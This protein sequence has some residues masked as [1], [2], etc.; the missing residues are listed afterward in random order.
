MG[1]LGTTKKVKNP[2]LKIKKEKIEHFLMH[3]EPFHWSHE[4]F[5]KTLFV[6]ILNLSEYPFVRGR[7]LLP[8]LNNTKFTHTYTTLLAQN[9][10]KIHTNILSVVHAYIHT[11]QKKLITNKEN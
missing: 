1:T 8:T 11:Q 7:Y 5:L 6:I 9:I 10:H 3:V 4:F 2:S